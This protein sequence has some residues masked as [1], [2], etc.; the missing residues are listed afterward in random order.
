MFYK[1]LTC[2]DKKSIQMFRGVD[3]LKMGTPRGR[4]YFKN[5]QK[6]TRGKGIHNRLN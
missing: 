6:R 1:L 4:G 5:I 3:K 2:R